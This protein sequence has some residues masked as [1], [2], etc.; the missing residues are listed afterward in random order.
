MYSNSKQTK[1]NIYEFSARRIKADKLAD[2]LQGAGG[3]SVEAGKMNEQCWAAVA[4]LAGVN[5]PSAATKQLAVE[6]LQAREQAC[7][8]LRGR[9]LYPAA[10]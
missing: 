9:N 3:T 7:E 5:P 2:V 10:A 6:I 4:S 8:Q 1:G